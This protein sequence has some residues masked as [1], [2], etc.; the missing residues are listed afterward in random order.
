MILIKPGLTIELSRN[1]EM[2][3][4]KALVIME[5]QM[6]QLQ[7]TLKLLSQRK[8]R[9]KKRLAVNACIRSYWHLPLSQL[10]ND[11]CPLRNWN[12]PHH[13]GGD[14]C[15]ENT[16]PCR[17]LPFKSWLTDGPSQSWTDRVIRYHL[18]RSSSDTRS[19]KSTLCFYPPKLYRP[20]SNFLPL[21]E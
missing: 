11:D 7:C 3:Y 18:D 21:P 12:N 1:H 14:V 17:L 9:A 15:S 19:W 2:N 20:T 5:Y 8:K 16:H 13:P 6:G 10:P 4:F